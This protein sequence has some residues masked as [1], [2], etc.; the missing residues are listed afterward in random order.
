M[1]NKDTGNDEAS[2]DER[3]QIT[4]PHTDH[5]TTQYHRNVLIVRQHLSIDEIIRANQTAL[6]SLQ[7]VWNRQCDMAA[8]AFR[9]LF[10]VIDRSVEMG[11]SVDPRIS[12]Y[13]ERSRQVFENSLAHTREMTD[14]TT[15]ATKE[16][17]MRAGCQARRYT[18]AL[19]PAPTPAQPKR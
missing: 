12:Q 14:M 16:L 1:S 19:Q 11:N 15:A 2:N 6:D 8:E 18:E 4:K 3:S 7:E 9:G 13:A 5:L 10:V 17:I